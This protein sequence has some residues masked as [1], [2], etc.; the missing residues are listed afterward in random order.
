MA[1][2]PQTSGRQPRIEEAKN[3]TDER[4]ALLA[5][6][7]ELRQARSYRE[8]VVAPKWTLPEARG[9]AA[10]RRSWSEGLPHVRRRDAQP[11]SDAG[12]S[13]TGSGS[14][15]L[16]A[17]LPTW[18]PHARIHLSLTD[19]VERLLLTMSARSMDRLLR[20]HRTELRRCI[21]GRTEPAST[22]VRW[23]PLSA[24]STPLGR[25]ALSAAFMIA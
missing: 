20:R 11:L 9:A 15:R 14:V 1:P 16:V 24:T 12:P 25:R 21:Q 6:P 8:V 18:M 10:Q 23:R 2:P 3:R 19:E 13:R 5:L 22:T 17:M 4:R 7:S